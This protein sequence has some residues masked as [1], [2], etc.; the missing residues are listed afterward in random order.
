MK[1]GI[2][3]KKSPMISDGNKNKNKKDRSQGSSLS[4]EGWRSMDP[5]D[6]YR[7]P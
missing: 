5:S 7:E 6:T 4:S 2:K 3:Q 1:R